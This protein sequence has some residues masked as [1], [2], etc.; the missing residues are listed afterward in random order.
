M[1]YVCV[2]MLVTGATLMTVSVTP[3]LTRSLKA[4]L[5]NSYAYEDNDDLKKD[6]AIS[7][8]DLIGKK[9]GYKT[10]QYYVYD[11]VDNLK[12]SIKQNKI[13]IRLYNKNI[14]DLKKQYKRKTP[15][16]IETYEKFIQPRINIHNF[17][18]DV[19]K[20]NLLSLRARLN[21]VIKYGRYL[22]FDYFKFT[23]DRLKWDVG[24][25]DFHDK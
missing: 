8:Q 18:I 15:E 21:N 22:K 19:A 4:K 24:K 12:D 20:E 2:A 1:W 7:H 14:N 25:H 9:R 6:F 23:Y 13:N 11:V 10:G 17:N 3:M 5:K 16:Q